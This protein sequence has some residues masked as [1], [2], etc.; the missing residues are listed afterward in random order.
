MDLF[1][2]CEGRAGCKHAGREVNNCGTVRLEACQGTVTQLSLK[3]VSTLQKVT[4]VHSYL[5]AELEIP[6]G[7]KV[8]AVDDPH[9]KRST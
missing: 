8:V 5:N 3:A 6:E 4:P 9:A 7:E 2:V 1:P